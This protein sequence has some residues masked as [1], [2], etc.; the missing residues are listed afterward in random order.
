MLFFGNATQH[1]DPAETTVFAVHKRQTRCDN[2]RSNTF[3]EH[4]LENYPRR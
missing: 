2:L 3:G 4:S 1:D